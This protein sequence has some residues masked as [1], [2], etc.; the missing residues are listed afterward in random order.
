M[1]ESRALAY[2]TVECWRCGGERYT[3]ESCMKCGGSC[4]PL[5]AKKQREKDRERMIV[6]FHA[7]E[8]DVLRNRKA[9]SRGR[10]SLGPEWADREVVLAIDPEKIGYVWSA[11]VE[12]DHRSISEELPTDSRGRVTLGSEWAGSEVTVVVMEAN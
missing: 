6:V 11:T 5:K 10:V 12:V 3:Y 2:E 4:K 1:R 7:E 8:K 9:D